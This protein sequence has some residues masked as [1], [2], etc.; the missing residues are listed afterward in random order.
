MLSIMSRLSVSITV[1]PLNTEFFTK[2]EF[3]VDKKSFE[4]PLLPSIK[5]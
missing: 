1:S 3:T 4:I 2:A 5:M